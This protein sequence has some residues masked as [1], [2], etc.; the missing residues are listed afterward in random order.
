MSS[1]PTRP[2]LAVDIDGIELN[3]ALRELVAKVRPT[4]RRSPASGGQ[5]APGV[6]RLVLDLQ[7]PAQLQVFSL[8]PVAAYQHRLVFDLYPTAVADPLEGLITERM[9]ERP[10][11]A[12]PG[13]AATAPQH[14][15]HPPAS[16][17]RPIPIRSV[18]D[19]AARR[20][21]A[22][23]RCIGSGAGSAV[24]GALTGTAPRVAAPERL[25]HR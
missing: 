12:V 13:P 17:P 22:C 3:A 10:G 14:C 1:W 7:Q 19:R 2:R 15:R 4:T 5:F 21:G 6:V 23:R 11:G 18:P 20:A 16:L 8:A 9:R 24:G 25:P